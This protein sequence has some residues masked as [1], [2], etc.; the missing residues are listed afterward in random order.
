MRIKTVHYNAVNLGTK[1]SIP[2]FQKDLTR[3][4]APIGEKTEAALIAHLLQ[5]RE[6]AA[7]FLSE[8]FPAGERFCVRSE[9]PTHD[10]SS[11]TVGPGDI[12]LL[13]MPEGS[14]HLA[15]A[16]Q[17]KQVKATYNKDWQEFVLNKEKDIK[18]LIMQTNL[19]SRHGFSR[20]Y[21]CLILNSD[22]RVAP[23]ANVV[24]NA[25]P[26]QVVQNL[27]DRILKSDLNANAGILIIFL[28]Q[29]MDKSIEAA[30]EFG[31]HNVRPARVVAQPTDLT[32]KINN[33]MKVGQVMQITRPFVVA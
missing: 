21:L 4:A 26:D 33:C 2:F 18:K 14:P 30:G 16:L 23:A 9:L 5:K 6:I 8:L 7:L 22:T 28:T 10:I 11:L 17:C 31:I 12:D 19:Q 27:L 3:N 13:A 20:S 25:V 1:S 29:A 24:V 15:V 32:E